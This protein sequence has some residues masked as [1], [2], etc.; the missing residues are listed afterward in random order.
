MKIL[1]HWLLSGIAVFATARV[2]PGVHVDTFATALVAAVV[3]ATV[4][5][6]LRPVLFILTLPINIMTL[7]LFTL[8]IIGGC[9]MLAARLVPGFQVTSFWWALAFAIALS[10]VN[11]V[12]HAAGR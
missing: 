12:L 6:L 7:G 11:G 2:L 1:V 5:A 9:V 10:I 4:N 3:L 8:V